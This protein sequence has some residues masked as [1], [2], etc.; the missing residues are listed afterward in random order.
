MKIMCLLQRGKLSQ[1]MRKRNSF[2]YNHFADFVLLVHKSLP[3]DNNLLPTISNGHIGFT[4]LSDS[5]YLNGLYN[6][7]KGLS[8]RARIPNEMNINIVSP[9]IT[10][11]TFTFN[12]KSGTFQIDMI[13]P[14]YSIVH[15]IYAHRFYNRAIINQV[16]IYR[17]NYEGDITV[18]V[19]RNTGNSSEDITFDH[20]NVIKVN[21]Q[22]VTAACGLTNEVEDPEYQVNLQ[23]VCVLWNRVPEQL[24]LKKGMQVMSFKFV[25]TVDGVLSVA[26]QEMTDVLT[27]SNSELFKKHVAEWDKFW[28]DFEIKV[29]GNRILSRAIYASIFYLVSSL[30][31][32]E[33]NIPTNAFYGLSPTGLGR[34]GKISEDYEGHNFWDT[35]IWMHPPILFMNPTWSKA[36]LNYR[37]LKLEAAKRNSV[38]SGFEGARFPWESAY[39]GLEVTQPC[40]PEVARNQI[41]VTA[42]ISFAIRNHFAATNDMQWLRREGCPLAIEIANFWKSRVVYNKSTHFY[43]IRDVMGPDEDHELVSN[44]VYTNVVAGY[45]LYF[46]DFASCL[47]FPNSN[48]IHSWKEIAKRIKLPYNSTYNYHPQYE[49]YQQGTIIKQADTVL[50]S[51]P[52]LYNMTDAVK[53]NDLLIYENVTRQT[54]PAMTWQIHAISHIE[55]NEIDK[56]DVFFRKSYQNYIRPPFNVWNEVI[57]GEKG[58]TNFITGSGGF[59]Q[60]VL[61]GYAG[62]KMFI[63]RLEIRNPRLPLMTDKLSISAIKYMGSSLEI[64]ICKNDTHIRCLGSNEDVP[65][66]IIY[67]NGTASLIIKELKYN[68]NSETVVIKRMRTAF[69]HCKIPDDIIGVSD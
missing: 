8:H 56:A 12:A 50:L 13:G 15:R 40:C 19:N 67:P 66:Q 18:D 3:E 2:S 60:T 48:T 37:F 57:Q 61:N 44:N 46:A 26:K 55:L 25:M 34:G 53:R 11:K 42:D 7:L 47:C 65:L 41:H 16:Y 54:G 24:T 49:G 58:A 62:I 31:S 35:E 9:S 10:N 5:V 4:V 6:G 69:G 14:D 22:S 21:N 29:T 43:D 23:Q 59:L 36:L 52:L 51:Y 45:A 38:L 64:N 32:N 1:S 28:N 39:T 17:L 63:D 33:T 20:K 27:V 30:P 68:I